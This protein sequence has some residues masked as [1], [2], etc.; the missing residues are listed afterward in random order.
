MKNLPRLRF[1]HLPT[2][3]EVLPRL[4]TVLEGPRLLV[5][6]DDQTGLALG[7]NKA[8]KLEYLLAEAQSN[9]AKTLITAGVDQS[10]HCRQTAA[11]A[12]RFGFDC[13][14]VL[15]KSQSVS[16]SG[17]LLLDELLGAEIVWTTHEKRDQDL[18]VTF[19]DAWDAGRRPY[20]IPYGGSNVTGAAAYAYA[21]QEMVEQGIETDW[22]IFPSGS[23]GTHAGLVLGSRLF[24]YKG[25]VLGISVD[26][27]A[28]VLAPRVAQLA[29]ATAEYLGEPQGFKAGEI[30][31]N[32][33][34]LG[35][36]YG[37]AGEAEKEAIR[38]FARSEGI[39]LDP[40]YTGR[41]AAG[42]IDLIRKRF[43]QKDQTVLFWHTGGT[44]ALFAEQYRDL[45]E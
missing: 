40:V 41:A 21:V 18:R 19:Q 2:P 28:N 31:A 24:G 20:M 11:A 27:P 1:A 8:R 37:V 30:L 36:G 13:I 16:P 42:M 12:A 14:L 6:R 22:I 23:G 26:E 33:D 38:L 44:P 34:Y 32:E 29:T 17:N 35:G 15:V 7:G 5:K 4:A 43:F 3:V 25:R 45:F 9:G 10:N 39:L